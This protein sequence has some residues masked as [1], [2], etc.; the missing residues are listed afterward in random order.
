MSAN[1]PTLGTSFQN[2]F[3]VVV[4]SLRSSRNPTVTQTELA[5][6]LGL[7]VSTWS[8]IERGESAITL[9]QMLRVALFFGIP[10]SELLLKCEDIAQSLNEQGIEVSISKSDIRNNNGVMPLSNA[11]VLS[12]ATVAGPIGWAAIGVF[13]AYKFLKSKTGKKSS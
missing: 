13:E 3:G 4:T 2:V 8:R 6:Y 12:I 5:D 11:Q 1:Q 10:L 7:A 9:D